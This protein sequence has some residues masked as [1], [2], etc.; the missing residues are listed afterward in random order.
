V[1]KLL[2]DPQL[3]V[4]QMLE[5]LVLAHP[6]Y[7]ERAG[8]DGRVIKRPGAPKPGKVGIVSGGGSGH[9]PVFTGYVGKGLL[10]ACA[11]GEVFSSPSVDQM[12]AAMRAV[13]GGAGVLRLYGNYGGDCMNFDMAG[14]MLA[15]E[16]VLS[17]TVL[18]ADDVASAPPVEANKRRGVAGMLYA[19]KLAGAAAEAGA[20][21]DEVTRVAQKA[22][23]SVRSIGAAL[24]SC[25]VPQAGRPTF[26][27]AEDEMEM[28]MGIHGEPGVWRG[29]LRPADAVAG[30]MLDY[31]LADMPLARGDHIS[32]LVNSLG[33]TPP[34]ELYILYRVVAARVADA[35]A[36]IVM[37]LVGRYATSM[38]MAGASITLCKLDAELEK[39]LHAPAECAF[40]R[41]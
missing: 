29:K 40:W 25:T 8:D 13:N 41:V 20:D 19:F 6:Q 4:E 17:T 37:P 1:K 15:M 10:D 9:L 5:G 38:E 18:L 3:Y 14:D 24:N 31:L 26:T 12:A 27:L 36:Q 22:A 2:N 21:L 11:I 34:E 39:L 16:D 35:G 30:E 32:V 7:Y 28:G 33:A 23:D